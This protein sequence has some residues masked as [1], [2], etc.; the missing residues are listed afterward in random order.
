LGGSKL[1][2]GWKA[3]QKNAQ[4]MIEFTIRTQNH[5]MGRAPQPLH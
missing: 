1:P 2:I 5:D 3:V 4:S